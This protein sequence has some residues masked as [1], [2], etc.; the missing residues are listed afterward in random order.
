MSRNLTKAEDL[1]PK[2]KPIF[3]RRKKNGEIITNDPNLKKTLADDG[4]DS[5]KD[6]SNTKSDEVWF[7]DVDPVLLDVTEKGLVGEKD[8][9][10][11]L[12]KA[13]SFTGLT[14]VGYYLI[15]RGKDTYALHNMQVLG[16]D[17]EMVGVGREGS[18][19]VLARVSIVNHFGH[20]VYDK[21]VA[22]REKVTD[23]R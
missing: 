1:G 20:P 2:E 16:M 21:F 23:Y 14:K 9:E 12:V 4:K 10:E 5:T 8:A 18:D 22:P 3:Y 17:C 6:A 7:D 15:Y 13:K 19:S 11:A